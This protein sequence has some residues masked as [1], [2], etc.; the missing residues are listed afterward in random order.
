MHVR[1]ERLRAVFTRTVGQRSGVRSGLFHVE[2]VMSSARCQGRT[3]LSID[4]SVPQVAIRL[5]NLLMLQMLPEDDV[6]NPLR[7][8]HR[9]S[10]MKVSV[11]SVVSVSVFAVGTG[12]PTLLL[13]LSKSAVIRQV[14][15][16]STGR[17]PVTGSTPDP[18]FGRSVHR[19]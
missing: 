11:G 1:V 7:N 13:P 6:V 10:V 9:L 15:F 12:E 3:A 5:R 2:A 14:I 19:S 17:I 8:G 16:A 4:A 18:F